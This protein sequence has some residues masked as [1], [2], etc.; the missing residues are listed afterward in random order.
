MLGGSGGGTAIA[1][2]PLQFPMLTSTT[3]DTIILHPP[4]LTTFAQT[5]AKKY[6][7]VFTAITNIAVTPALVVGTLK[8]SARHAARSTLPMRTYPTRIIC[9]NRSSCTAAFKALNWYLSMGTQKGC[10]IAHPVGRSDVLIKLAP[11]QQ[12]DI[13]KF[14][15][16][17]KDC[18]VDDSFD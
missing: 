1:A 5:T 6:L 14:N 7:S 17:E 8:A 15:F 10:R 9:Y 13:S 3:G 16:F 2:I 11:G 12:L 18:L 4:M